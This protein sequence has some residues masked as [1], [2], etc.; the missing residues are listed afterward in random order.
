MLSDQRRWTTG[1]N[2]GEHDGGTIG[3][4]CTAKIQLRRLGLRGLSRSA[5][6][7]IAD[8]ALDCA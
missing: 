4:R 2:E 6:T 1:H 5:V 7:V 3:P 8:L